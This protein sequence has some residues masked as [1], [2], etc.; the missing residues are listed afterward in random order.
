MYCMR[1]VKQLIYGI[2]YLALW[3]GLIGGIYAWQLPTPTCFDNRQNQ[4][5]IGVDC[6]GVCARVCIPATIAP[7]AQ[8]GE[9][10]MILLGSAVGTSGA[11]SSSAAAAPRVSIVS[12][13]QNRNLDFGASSFDYVFKIYDQGGALIVSLPARSF[14]YPG[15]VKRL[16]LL[17]QTLPAGSNPVTA[18]LA[19]QNPL[20][21][22][23]DRFPRPKLTIQTA[24]TAETNGNLVTQ[25]ILVNQDNIDFPTVYLTAVYYDL[26]G[27]IVG[28][29]GTERNNV[30]AG[31]SREFT[32]FHPV[33]TNAAPEKTQVFVTAMNL[34]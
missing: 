32:L 14:I 7:L 15:E 23:A 6:G 22:P 29:S 25:G 28:V 26:N 24:N 34:R 3:A 33:I 8:N 1:H 27:A 2:F 31:E 19:L 10:K 4:N 21:T 30:T 17:N 9:P 11:A 18:K 5:E 16:V 20:W 13:I 12:E